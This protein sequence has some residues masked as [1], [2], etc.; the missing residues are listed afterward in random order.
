MSSPITHRVRVSFLLLLL[1]L[2]SAVTGLRHVAATRQAERADTFTGY[3]PYVSVPSQPQFE[4]VQFAT[5]FDANTIADIA[6]AGDERL[7]VVQRNGIIR[8]VRPD[9]TLLPEPFLDLSDEVSTSNFEEGMLGLAFHPDYPRT[10]YFY[11][12]Y[13]DVSHRIRVARYTV[14]PSMP[15]VADTGSRIYLLVL[16]KPRSTGGTSPVHN[17]GDLTFGKDGYL[18]IPLGDGGPDPYDPMGVPGD[19]NNNGQMT[20]RLL[21]SILRIDVN[22][23]AGLPS[24]CGNKPTYSIPA[25]NP[26]VDREGCDEIWAKGLRNPW[27][28]AVDP[29]TGDFFIADVGEWKRE[30]VNYYPA[31]A[32]GG[33]NFGWHCR[34]GSVD[35]TTIHPE[36]AEDCP[37]ETEFIYPVYEYDHSLGEC[38]IIGGHV[39]RGA[40]YPD[41]YGRYFFGDFCTGRVWTMFRN[42]DQWAVASAGRLPLQLAT[43]GEDV[44]GEIYVGGYHFQAQTINLYKVVVH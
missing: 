28:I 15:N 30:E 38:S 37:D 9:G 19:P 4:I 22:P 39:Y 14:K 10:P 33:A 21:G 20:T 24:D 44:N 35:Y 23:A 41:L 25:D 29:L 36:L 1:V 3:M 7:F 8:I 18:Y 26:Y 6:H 16:D 17:G 31:G 43:F 2:L 32:P 12:H 34:E 13:T 27:R 5:G 11:V 42:G 40:A